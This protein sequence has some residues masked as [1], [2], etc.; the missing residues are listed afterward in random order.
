[1]GLSGVSGPAALVPPSAIL[2]PEDLGVYEFSRPVREWQDVHHIIDPQVSAEGMH[3]WPFAPAFPMDVRSFVFDER[4]AARRTRH[5]YFELVYVYSGSATYEV[6]DQQFTV[7][8][9]DLIVVNGNLFHGLAKVQQ[10]TFRAVVLYFHP[11]ILCATDSSSEQAQYLMPFLLQDN[12]FPHVVRNE[13]GLSTRVFQLMEKIR[14]ELPAIT[15]GQRLLAR[16]SLEVILVTLINHYNRQFAV[17]EAFQKRQRALERLRPLF[18]YIEHHYARQIT[19][20]DATAIV[21]MSKPHFM[22]CFK[23]ATGQ[24]F[25]RYLNRFRIAKAQVLLESSDLSIADV[26]QQVGF[27]YQSYFGLVFRRLVRLT[28]REYRKQLRMV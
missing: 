12:G 1:M 27:C 10:P 19:L 24:S 5:E 17:A 23:R 9:N 16:A 13:A 22:R 4:H 25:D 26:G 7:G 20:A 11:D 21:K 28:P 18:N 14:E 2:D 6:E 3:V 15:D 8:E